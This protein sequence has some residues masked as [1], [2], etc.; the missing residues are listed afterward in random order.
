MKKQNGIINMIALLLV[1][2]VII[3][4]FF[5]YVFFLRDIISSSEVPVVDNTASAGEVKNEVEE[6]V[7]KPGPDKQ[8]IAYTDFDYK[9]LIIPNVL[10]SIHLLIAS[11][12][13]KSS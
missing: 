10:S 7:V 9:F 2:L 6:P 1:A 11:G 4:M 8:K 5:F 13:L 12:D 3:I